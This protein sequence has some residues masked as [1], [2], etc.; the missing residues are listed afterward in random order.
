LSDGN[1]NEFL[2]RVLQRS[3]LASVDNAHGIHPNFADKH[4]GK[5]GPLLNAGP[6]LK[7]NANQRYATNSES[8]SLFRRVCAEAGVPVQSYVVRTDMA[9]GST[10]G[11]IV[12]TELGISTVDIGIP[13]FAMHSIRELCGSHDTQ[14]LVAA[15][16]RFYSSRS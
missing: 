14:H 6:V 2:Q 13:T 15:L 11:P 12:A 7:F 3:V 5:H 4:D 8:S 9:C 16:T 1:G 10:I